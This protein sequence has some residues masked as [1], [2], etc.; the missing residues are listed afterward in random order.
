MERTTA[1]AGKLTFVAHNLRISKKKSRKQKFKNTPARSAYSEEQD[2]H[3]DKED[4]QQEQ[5][6]NIP[7]STADFDDIQGGGVRFRLFTS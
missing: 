2:I 5:E 4:E 7:S 6:C 1:R 3:L